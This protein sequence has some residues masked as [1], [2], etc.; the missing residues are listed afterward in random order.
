LADAFAA[1]LIAEEGDSPDRRISAM[2]RLALAREP[3]AEEASLS[4]AALKQLTAE[5]RAALAADA[6]EA[7]GPSAAERAL[8]NLCHAIMNSAELMYVD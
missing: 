4:L 1:R 8:G 6:S 5:W 3:T 2:Y 7:A